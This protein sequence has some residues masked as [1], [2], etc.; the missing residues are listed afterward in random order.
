MAQKRCRGRWEKLCPN[1]PIPSN[2]PILFLLEEA[3][4]FHRDELNLQ[5]LRHRLNSG[6]FLYQQLATF[7]RA[8]SPRPQTQNLTL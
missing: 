7:A 1:S 4:D 5:G 2:G 6:H 8:L 3:F